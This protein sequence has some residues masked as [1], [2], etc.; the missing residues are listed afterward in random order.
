VAEHRHVTSSEWERNF[1]KAENH[2]V[3]K[4][5]I[6]AVEPEYRCL[7][8][9]GNRAAC[10][11]EDRTVLRVYGEIKNSRDLRLVLARLAELQDQIKAEVRR[12]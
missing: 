9:P 10:C 3:R 7:Y 1:G 2:R 11:V 12:G 6:V 5:L 4:G 8:P